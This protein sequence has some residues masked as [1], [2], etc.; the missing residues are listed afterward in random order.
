VAGVLPDRVRRRTFNLP[1]PPQPC[2]LGIIES[3]FG[4]WLA[5]Q[6]ADAYVVLDLLSLETIG[7][8]FRE[9]RP[10]VIGVIRDLLPLLQAADP[11]NCDNQ[12]RR[13]CNLRLQALL[14]A[15]ALL[16]MSEVIESILRDLVPN[17]ASRVVV[18]DDIAIGLCHGLGPRLT[19]TPR[20]RKRIAWVSPLPPTPSGIA[21]YSADMLQV[22]AHH[23]DIDLV[24]DPGQPDVDGTLTS[25]FWTLTPAE[26]SQRHAA[27][28]YDLFVYQLG[29]SGYHVYMLELMRRFRGLVVLHDFFMGG[30]VASCREQGKW[31]A[32]LCE[33]LDHEGESHLADWYRLGHITDFVVRQMTPLNRRILEL[34]DAVVVHSAWSWQRVR[35]IV[36]VPVARVPMPMPITA[37]RNAKKM[38]RRKLGIPASSFVICSLG[39]NGHVKRLP[40]LLRG[41]AGLPLETRAACQVVLV[42]PMDGDS[43]AHLVRMANSLGLAGQVRSTGWVSAEEFT[44]FIQAADVCVQ[45]RY[46][47]FGETSASVLRALAAGTPCITSDQGP[48]AELPNEIVP[49]VRSPHHEVE[50]LTAILGELFA[51]PNRLAELAECS[52]HYVVAHHHPA[53]SAETYAAAIEQ[54]IARRG[55]RD[56]NWQEV[57]ARLLEATP[58]ATGERDRLIVQWAALREM[59]RKQTGQSTIPARTAA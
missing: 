28:P 43:A 48:M 17:L 21:D 53:L 16:V 56:A 36:D 52:R 55:K 26:V 33:E 40:S 27:R 24:V 10:A 54:T 39:H 44:D 19:P 47:T 7:P 12:R 9:P 15:D 22:L 23:F 30:F 35:R 31:P 42:G 18:A 1:L 49:K 58:L 37:Q 11:L 5:A 50:D 25:R 8:R 45:L 4:D 32:A 6:G 59:V 51:Q 2:Y 20:K 57:T 38:L 14:A 29:N 3:Y 34:A 13:W 41:V 46:P